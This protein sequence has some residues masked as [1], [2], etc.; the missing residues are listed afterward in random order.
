MQ[1]LGTLG[2]QEIEDMVRGMQ[3]SLKRAEK[4]ARDAREEVDKIGQAGEKAQ[5]AVERAAGLMG[6]ALADVSDVVFDLVPAIT[7]AGGAFG[8]LGLAAT[9]A[10]AAIVAGLAVG[11]VASA[12][13]EHIISSATEAEER[14]TEA[15]LAAHIPQT[16]QRALEDYRRAQDELAVSVDLLTLNILGDSGLIAAFT[17]LTKVE[18]EL[19]GESKTLWGWITSTY[20][21]VI[22]LNEAL[23]PIVTVVN[24][25]IG[26]MMQAGGSADDLYDSLVR[27]GEYNTSLAAVLDTTTNRFEITDD[28]IQALSRS[29]AGTE[30]TSLASSLDVVTSKYLELTSAME[31]HFAG[32]AAKSTVE[33]RGLF[34]AQ[35]D[36]GLSVDDA[37]NKY[38]KSAEKMAEALEGPLKI[39]NAVQDGLESIS[40]TIIASYER[41]LEAGEQLT[42]KEM[43][44]LKR[45][46]DLR[47]AAALSQIA[48]D[49][50]QAFVGLFA[51]M[52]FLGPL[53]A[54]AAA[55]LVTAT[56]VPAVASVF[57]ESPDLSSLGSATSSGGVVDGSGETGIGTGTGLGNTGR[58]GT[59][60][61][62][63]ASGPVS[64]AQVDAW[65]NQVWVSQM[66]GYKTGRIQLDLLT[67]APGKTW[68]GR[69]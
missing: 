11:S 46:Q 4:A 42:E 58:G 69:R 39:A 63:F 47:K 28:E 65:M 1:E 5:R 61:S 24:P 25:V 8:A 34:M 33:A 51:A 16:A 29:L 66:M 52:S 40:D 53:A 3:R 59:G 14:L 36:I 17:G 37:G 21:A 9:G 15:G 50:V 31:K 45:A 27:I 26:G 62:L 38:E 48:I 19:I 13:I 32:A 12:A 18:R 20:D 44:G 22:D 43:Q 68:R 23:A 7:G 67:S 54:P 6:G 2:K 64:Q 41:R 35:E 60:N 57:G 10:A 30:P 56:V 49:A 55:A